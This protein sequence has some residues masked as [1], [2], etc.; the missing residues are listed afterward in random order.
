[1]IHWVPPSARALRRSQGGSPVRSDGSGL[2][3]QPASTAAE[4]LRSDK[5]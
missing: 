5:Q 3:F 2:A 1:L 4:R